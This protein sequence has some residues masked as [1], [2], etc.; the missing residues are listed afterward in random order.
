MSE[1][2]LKSEPGR[3]GTT[4]QLVSMTRTNAGKTHT[5]YSLRRI[6]SDGREIGSLS[7]SREE[8]ESFF[9]G[10]IGPET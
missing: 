2:I 1:R 4:L 9:P 5:N 7:G 6:A 10:F 8:F 3:A